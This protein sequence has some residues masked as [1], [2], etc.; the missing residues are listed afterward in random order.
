MMYAF[1][2]ELHLRQAQDGWIPDFVRDLKRYCY[3]TVGDSLNCLSLALF[4]TVVRYA[5]TRTIFNPFVKWAQLTEEN[6]K[7]FP[8]SVWKFLY[9]ACTASS[10]FYMCA[11]KYPFFSRP[12]SVWIGWHRGV[13]VPA[14]IY[15]LYITQMGFY[16]HSFYATAMMDDVRKDYFVMYVHHTV[17]CLL[18]GF[19]LAIRYHNIGVLLF[20]L[21]D[22]ND[23]ILEGCKCLVYLKVQGGKEYWIWEMIANV[24]FAVFCVTWLLMRVYWFFYKIIYNTGY[25]AVTILP[26]GP[27]YFFF[28][29]MLWIIFLMNCWWYIF[30]ILA[31]VRILAGQKLKDTRE[32]SSD[33]EE[34]ATTGKE[35]AVANETESKNVPDETGSENVPDD[36]RHVVS[37]TDVG[38]VQESLAGLDLGGN[39]GFG[40]SDEEEVDMMEVDE[41]VEETEEHIR[42]RNVREKGESGD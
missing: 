40:D 23:V 12:E 37:G 10:C 9:Y 5:L 16:I 27:F 41:E 6:A 26:S 28:N 14:D 42:K 18:I 19:S 2:T 35:E 21:H 29:F 32:Q 30:I 36:T 13:E 4:F 7:K 22:I 31:A 39:V 3:W 15:L 20:T 25:L 1:R 11:T 17:S 38:D 24:G 8:E 33:K 34:T